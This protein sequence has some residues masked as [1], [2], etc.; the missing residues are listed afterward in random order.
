MNAGAINTKNDVA[1]DYKRYDT[2]KL[3]TKYCLCVSYYKY[4]DGAKVFEVIGYRT[5]LK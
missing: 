3:C 4:G 2:Y 5:K 1:I